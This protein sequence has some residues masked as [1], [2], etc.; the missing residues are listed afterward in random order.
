MTAING[1]ILFNNSTG[2]DTAASGVGP[3]TAVS[4]SGASTTSGSTVVTGI[5]TTGVVSG[6][7]QF[8][9]SSSGRQSSVISSVDSGS[10]VTC[11]DTFD[12]TE[13]S[14]NWGIGGKRASLAGS[15]Q[16]Y[17]SGGDLIGGSTI[18][19][20]DG[21]TETIAST[22]N[23]F[24][25]ASIS[26]GK[27]VLLTESGHTARA[28]ITY[29]GASQLMI[30]RN[31]GFDF[32]DMVFLVSGSAGTIIDSVTDQFIFTRCFFGRTGSGTFTD[33][34]GSGAAEG[35]NLIECEI[36][37]TGGTGE[38]ARMSDGTV[39]KNCFI[40]DCAGAGV[41]FSSFALGPHISDSIIAN[42][43]THGISWGFSGTS[44]RSGTIT[45]N[46]LYG[47]TDDGIRISGLDNVAWNNLPI[48]ANI[49]V[50]NG[51]YGLNFSAATDAN[52]TDFYVGI[53]NRNAYFDNTSGEVNNISNGP[54]D[55]S[56]TADPFLNAAG[57]DWNLNETAGGGAVL[58]AETADITGATIFPFNQWAIPPSGGGGGDTGKTIGPGSIIG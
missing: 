58:R 38:G 56:L 23:F 21:Y 40:H 10:Q 19:F 35:G 25:S 7:L 11:D 12:N 18:E 54:N 31:T 4:G 32:R 37:G 43:G 27:V 44:N 49:L 39:I 30:P 36:D 17:A 13:G 55:I 22:L 53:N 45:G 34:F 2:S 8:V 28:T 29:S 41:N 1:N 47:N 52:E 24:N 50:S 16:L 48:H 33:A 6:D 3:A 5:D 15:A 51:G 42:N 9:G 20:S 46:I 57:D 14:R 26:T